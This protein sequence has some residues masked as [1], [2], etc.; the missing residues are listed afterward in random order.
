MIR[1]LIFDFDGLILDTEIPSFQTWQ[2]IYQAHGRSLDFTTW[3]ACIGGSIELFNPYDHLEEQLGRPVDREALREQ[4]RRRH[5]ALVEAQSILPGVEQ[6]IADARRLGLKIGLASSSSRGWA[7]GHLERLGLHA[8]FDCI[9]C[10]DHVTHTKPDPELYLA[11]L[12]ALHVRADEAFALE[13]SPNGVRAAQRAGLFCVAVPNTLTGQLS[14][15][16]ADL[17]LASLADMPLEELIE[18]IQGARRSL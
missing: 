4:Y 8:H 14:L 13:D 11:V 10:A 7:A 3:S 9:R 17:R 12:E 5:V 6:Y 1:A 16:H 18:V 15:D 2:E